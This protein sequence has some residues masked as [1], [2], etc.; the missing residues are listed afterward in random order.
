[1]L[2]PGDDSISAALSLLK[3]MTGAE[4]GA[5]EGSGDRRGSVLSGMDSVLCGGDRT[6]GKMNTALLA[7]WS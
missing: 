6:M 5:Q 1:M 2:C 3:T 7:Q 4:R